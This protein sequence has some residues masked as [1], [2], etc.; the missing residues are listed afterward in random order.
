[1]VTMTIAT[2]MANVYGSRSKEC[3][4]ATVREREH[5]SNNNESNRYRQS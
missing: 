4:R 3:M 1:M 5:D 2:T